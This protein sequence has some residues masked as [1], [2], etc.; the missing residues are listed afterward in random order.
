[1]LYWSAVFLVIALISAA[2]GFF[3]IAAE[4]GWIAKI[5]FF[6]FLVLA[7]VSFVFGRRPRAL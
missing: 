4:A 5:L 2:F 1:M 7:I 3:G 6:A